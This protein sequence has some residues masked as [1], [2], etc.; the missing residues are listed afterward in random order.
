MNKITNRE[1]AVFKRWA[2][3]RVGF[4][5]DGLPFPEDYCRSKVRTILILRETNGK[6][7]GDLREHLRNVPRMDFWGSKVSPWCCGF[8][9]D[10]LGLRAV[11]KEALS[12]HSNPG[13]VRNALRPFGYMQLKKE[14]GGATSK[15]VELRK[16]AIN[17][18]GMIREQLA[19][20]APQIII[21]CGLGTPTTFD[22]LCKFVFQIPENDRRVKRFRNKRRYAEIIDR[23][24]SP[25]TIYLIEAFHPS[26]RES[27][28]AMFNETVSNFRQIQQRCAETRR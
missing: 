4:C 12:N 24:L 26:A 2:V 21:A 3:K 9:N 18:Q 27:R 15:A 7:G 8:A 23:E 19:I 28:Q 5:K 16:A 17:D 14:G 10:G 6:T 22:L 11:W 1:N 25:R 13:W 20:Y